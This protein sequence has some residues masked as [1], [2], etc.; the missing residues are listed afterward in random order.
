MSHEFFLNR[1]SSSREELVKA[2]SREQSSQCLDVI[3]S[4]DIMG[5]IENA[6]DYQ[7]FDDTE[8]VRVK[9]TLYLFLF[10]SQI[11]PWFVANLK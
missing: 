8:Q 1:S 5:D 2:E 4:S 10:L 7:D 6:L 3:S 9:K 11:L